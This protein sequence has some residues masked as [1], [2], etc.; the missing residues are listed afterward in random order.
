M[1]LSNVLTC[2]QLEN[3][4]GP[5]AEILWT[6][7]PGCWGLTSSGSPGG[8]QREVGEQTKEKG[9][10]EKGEK[11]A[12]VKRKTSKSDPIISQRKLSSY[13]SIP[14]KQ[15]SSRESLK[16][17][18]WNF[19]IKTDTERTEKS[20]CVSSVKLCRPHWHLEKDEF[21]FCVCIVPQC[22]WSEIHLLFKLEHEHMPTRHILLTVTSLSLLQVRC[23]SFQNRRQL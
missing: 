13:Q 15:I 7:K 8:Q 4:P 21:Q 18:Q 22:D 3:R 11:T 14:S 1:W 6:W 17:K 23:S 19:S 20:F 9:W 2:R 5:G 12:E 10:E 16:K